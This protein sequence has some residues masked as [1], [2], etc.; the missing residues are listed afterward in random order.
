MVPNS[1]SLYPKN[2]LIVGIREAHEEKQKPERKK[3]ILR[4]RRCLSLSSMLPKFAHK[5][6]EIERI[7]RFGELNIISPHPTG[8]YTTGSSQPL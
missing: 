3:K 4:K 7:A 8:I 5:S 1:A 2:V 6:K